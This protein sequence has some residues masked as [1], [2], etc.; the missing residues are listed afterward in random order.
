MRDAQYSTA[1]RYDTLQGVIDHRP[2]AMR[3]PA[4]TR[5]TKHDRENLRLGSGQA[6]SNT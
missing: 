2:A 5:A 1:G 4:G 3:K 6:G